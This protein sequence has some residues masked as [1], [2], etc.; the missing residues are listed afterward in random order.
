ML[1]P[2][3]RL[4]G[5]WPGWRDHAGDLA[6]VPAAGV[7]ALAI[8]VFSADPAEWVVDLPEAA[9]VAFC[10]VPDGRDGMPILLA[11]VSLGPV[12]GLIGLAGFGR[13]RSWLGLILGAGLAAFWLQRFVLHVPGCTP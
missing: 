9:A 3:A 8:R 6:L 12:L 11:L 7:T 13:P 1:R 2:P 5:R 10:A 4:P